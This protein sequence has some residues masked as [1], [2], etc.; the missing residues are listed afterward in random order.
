MKKI[1]IS[2]FLIAAVC[3]LAY[4]MTPEIVFPF[5]LAAAIH[6]ASHILVCKL[7]HAELQSFSL[8]L[9]GA[10]LK[11]AFRNDRQEL[12]CV[13]AGP[14]SNLLCVLLFFR[15]PYFAFFS[16]L[17]AIYN[18]LPLSSLDGGR[19]LFLLLPCS[20]SVSE[21][22]CRIVESIVVLLLIGG[23]IVLCCYYHAGL[24]SVLGCACLLIRSNLS[25]KSLQM[26]PRRRK[27]KK[28]RIEGIL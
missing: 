15:A 23:C 6:E 2:P 19:L 13:A 1:D 5:L 4:C 25:E 14:L 28:K 16:L 7:F 11:A 3:V 27:I 9:G 24:W 17:L 21:T 12:I 22:I 10:E 8:G 26:L 18:L 20:F